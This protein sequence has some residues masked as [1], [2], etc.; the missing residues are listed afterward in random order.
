MNPPTPCLVDSVNHDQWLKNL[1]FNGDPA[2]RLHC[3]EVH[4]ELSQLVNIEKP[5]VPIAASTTVIKLAPMEPHLSMPPVWL[6]I[7]SILQARVKSMLLG[8]RRFLK[9]LA[10]ATK[11]FNAV[12]VVLYFE[13]VFSP[14][15]IT[16]AIDRYFLLII[17][18]VVCH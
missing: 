5:L 16:D 8:A 2:I 18:E 11:K 12:I 6:I 7:L 17:G 10:L 4:E 14:E 9:S 15:S 1:R 3:P 13:I